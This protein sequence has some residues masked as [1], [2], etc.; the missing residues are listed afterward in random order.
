[1]LSNPIRAGT[2]REVEDVLDLLARLTL[3]PCDYA[4]A[5]ISSALGANYKLKAADAV[6]L[7][8]AVHASA[9][10]FATNN[11]RDFPQTIEEI[12]INYPDQPRRT[13]RRPA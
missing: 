8:T 4:I 2:T 7:A 1:M 10:R 12:E 11:S 3:M 5:E 13:P 9:D 6:H